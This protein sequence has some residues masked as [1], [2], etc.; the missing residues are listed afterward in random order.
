MPHDDLPDTEPLVLAQH[1]GSVAVL[2]LNR[3]AKRNAISLAMVRELDRCIAA[4]P[5]DV[6]AVVLAARGE[7]F[8]AGLDLSEVTEQ[9][10]TQG[11]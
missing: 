10:V 2:E 4:L 3:P 11:I 6:K 7:H 9:D 5:D 8:S 1:D